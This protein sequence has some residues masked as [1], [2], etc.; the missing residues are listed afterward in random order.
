MMDTISIRFCVV[1]LL[2]DCFLCNP[3]FDRKILEG[4]LTSIYAS[5]NIAPDFIVSESKMAEIQGFD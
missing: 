5:W 3:G 1:E 2:E 4:V